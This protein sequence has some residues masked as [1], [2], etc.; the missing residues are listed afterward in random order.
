MS[1]TVFSFGEI[2]WDLLPDKRLLGGAPFNFVY[3]VHSL[4]NAGYII[5]SIGND[6]LG[7]EAREAV[8]GLGLETTYLQQDS[9]HP[10]GTVNVF[11][12]EQNNPDYFIVPDV[13]YDFV[14]LTDAL[15]QAMR[16]ADCLCFGSLAQRAETS[17]KTV[18]ALIEEAEHALKFFDINMRKQCYNEEIITWSLSRANALKLNEDEARE[19]AAMLGMRADAI[20]QFSKDIIKKQSLDYCVVT[21]GDKG[22]FAASAKGEQAYV[23]GY[24]IALEDSLGSGDAFSAGF[25]DRV[26]NGAGV[27]DACEYG[28]ILG[29]IVATQKGATQPISND[30]IERFKAANAERITEKS[31]AQ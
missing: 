11:F 28:N 26:L 10:T 1:T 22:A 16:S 8:A 25:I 19:L 23:P 29:A 15:R 20:A 6:E 31:L 13:A 9:G 18:R 14:Q 27:A 3:R 30:E 17:R 5:S 2:L 12:D 7:E 21:L 4:G 24:K